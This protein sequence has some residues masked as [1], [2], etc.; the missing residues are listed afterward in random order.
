VPSGKPSASGVYTVAGQNYI[1]QRGR[2][3]HVAFDADI[4]GWR[5]STPHSPAS[6]KTGGPLERLPDG[7]WQ[8]RSVG[9]PG[10]GNLP[11]RHS[12]QQLPDVPAPELP[13][14]E[15]LPTEWWPDNVYAYLPGQIVEHGAGVASVTLQELRVSRNFN[16]GIPVT[17]LPPTAP[18]SSLPSIVAPWLFD[19]ANTTAGATLGSASGRW[20]RIDLRKLSLRNT[21]PQLSKTGGNRPFRLYKL[22]N[23]HAYVLRP[24]DRGARQPDTAT[25]RAVRLFGDEFES[26]VQP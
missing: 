26:T 19:Q 1:Q 23:E 25:S 18:L 17:T 6:L 3:Y 13:R 24:M 8:Y 12:Y 5:L 10:G 11:G 15:A 9:L 14:L 22:E 20:I 7:S 4:A 16:V 21:S 2:M